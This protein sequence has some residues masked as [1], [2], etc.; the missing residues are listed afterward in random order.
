MYKKGQKLFL[1]EGNNINHFKWEGFD[2]VAK[3]HE[4]VQDE[5]ERS[6]KDC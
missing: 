3:S 6:Q 4:M 5:E 2:F 1:K